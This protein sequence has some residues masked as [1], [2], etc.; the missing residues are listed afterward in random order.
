MLKTSRRSFMMGAG[1]IALASTAGGNFAFAADRRALRIGVNG[2]PPSLEPINGISNTGPRII[3]QIFDTLIRRD[4]FADGAKGNSIKLVPSLAESFERID[5]K[6]V[7]FKLRQGVKFHNGAE[8][9][10]EDVA[11]TFSSERL[12][13]DEAIKTVPNGRNFSPNWDEPVVEDKYTVVL[14]AKTPSYL[15]E[16][17]LGSWLGPIV[18]KEYYQSLGAVAF[19]N[20]PIGTGP[21]KFKELVAND[22]VTLEANDGYWGDKPTAST[23][24]YQVVAEPATRVAG[25]IS[26]E[27]DII[28]TLT[29]DDMALV[30]GYSDL[31]TRGTLIENVH[32]FTFNMNQPI[33]QNKTLRRALALAVNRPLMVEA[34]WKN[35]ASIPNGFNFPHYGASYDP[36]RKPME[37][38]L[39]EAK[40][41][42]KESGYDGTPITYH[43]MGNYYANA[44]PALMM[45]IEMWKA[46]G[47]NVVPKIFAP[48]TTPKDSDILIRNWSN[49]QWLTDG[50]T[51]IVSE[52][53]PG[54]GIQKR[55]GWKAPA[56]FND[57]CDKVAQ[58]KDGE[59]RSAA[60]NRLRDIFEDEAPAVL[61]YQPYDVYAAR[62]DVQ[63]S[64]VSFETMEFRGNL[65]FK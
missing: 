13:G 19:G 5:D 33:F 32:M 52:F 21:Y 37:Y 29:P 6:S 53:G 11:F 65:N 27:Y 8:M 64:P 3:N 39:E 57:L 36:K 58:L 30:D 26:G 41:L 20:K 50:L 24:T 34:L 46:A 40:R 61:M 54:R 60:F 49:G 56:E 14:R 38:N 48:G 28:T 18:P 25:L 4:Y 35:K 22:H 10:A 45:M 42:V 15:I 31:E 51:T 2:L 23:I 17:Y 7:R 16:K 44:V 59:E 9:T 62:K 63:W 43:T 55:W 1:A 12:W 47:I